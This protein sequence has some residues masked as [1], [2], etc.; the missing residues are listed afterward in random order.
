MTEI[1]DNEE[2][3]LDDKGGCFTVIAPFGLALYAI[4]IISIGLA[5]GFCG[6]ST[7]FGTWRQDG[8]EGRKLTSG[9]GAAQWRLQELRRFGLI[10]RSQTPILYHDHSFMADGSS[11]CYV[12]DDTVTRWDNGVLSGRVSIIGSTV[13]GDSSD[14]TVQNGEDVVT[15]PFGLMQGGGDFLS[16]LQT[17]ANSADE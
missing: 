5:A 1:D 13:S 14:V 16:M 6:L 12:I 7:M 3:N 10:E 9:M 11:G 4:L 8:D 2:L 15:C 17:T